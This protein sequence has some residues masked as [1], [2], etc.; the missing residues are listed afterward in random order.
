MNMG[1]RWEELT[2]KTQGKARACQNLSGIQCGVKNI[3][4]M[5]K[6]N[7]TFLLVVKLSSLLLRMLLGGM[8][9]Q[10]GKGTQFTDQNTHTL[11]RKFELN[12]F[13]SPPQ[14]FYT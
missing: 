2:P 1:T 5:E 7:R 11:G 10:M 6:L 14:N 4:N 13:L 12:C 3:P 9:V 8:E